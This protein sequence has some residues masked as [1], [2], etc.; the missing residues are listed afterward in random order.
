MEKAIVEWT[1][2]L[3]AVGIWA[4]ARTGEGDFTRR[5]ELQLRI[6]WKIPRTL[7]GGLDSLVKQSHAVPRHI[8]QGPSGQLAPYPEHH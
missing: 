2:D 5:G 8:Q 7:P 3:I 4:T 6:S 1:A